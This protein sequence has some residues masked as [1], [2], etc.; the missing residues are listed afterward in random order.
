MDVVNINIFFSALL[1]CTVTEFPNMGRRSYS[2]LPVHKVRTVGY[3]KG[4]YKQTMKALTI[5]DDDIFLK[6]ATCAL[7]SQNSRQYCE[8]GKLSNY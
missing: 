1:K 6:Q 2:I 4:A 5:F 3:I 7:T 8:G